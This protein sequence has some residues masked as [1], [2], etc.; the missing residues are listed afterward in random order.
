[1]NV[2]RRNFGELALRTAGISV[3]FPAI[4]PSGANAAGVT[5]GDGKWA[6]HVGVFQEKE[7]ADGFVVSEVC[8]HMFVCVYVYVCVC[9][10][11]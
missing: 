7:F 5:R 2:D 9:V 8:K 3:L 10:C 11:V 1:M 4:L 6:E